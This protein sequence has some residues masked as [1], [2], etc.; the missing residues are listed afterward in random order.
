MKTITKVEQTNS[1]PPDYGKIFCFIMNII[2]VRYWFCPCKYVAP[3]G[4]AISLDCPPHD[5]REKND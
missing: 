1:S 3:Y 2:D 5:G 4:L